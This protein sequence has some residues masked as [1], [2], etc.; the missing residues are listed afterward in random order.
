MSEWRPAR[1]RQPGHIVVPENTKGWSYR[2]L[3]ARYF[4]GARKITV[5]DPYIRH[6]FQARNLMELLEVIHDLVPEGDEVVVH[7]ITQSDAETCVRQAENLNQM[8]TAL[9]ARVCLFVGARSQSEFSRAQHHNGHRL[10]NHHR[11]RAGHIPEV[12]ERAV[13]CGTS[14]PKKR[15]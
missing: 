5:S 9:R 8:V 3:F 10:E 6:F 4:K 11:P 13:F 15:A 1:H 14:H 7:L 2:R 12:R